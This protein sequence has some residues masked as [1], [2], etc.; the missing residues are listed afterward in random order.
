M[1]DADI[2]MDAGGDT[3]ADDLPEFLAGDGEDED[4]TEDE[5]QSMIAAE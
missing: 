4:A 1:N 5:D 2:A 3:E